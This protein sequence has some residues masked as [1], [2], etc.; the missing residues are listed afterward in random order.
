MATAAK[1]WR[2]VL[3]GRPGSGKSS[4]GESIAAG[5]GFTLV[6]TGELLRDA[7][8][9]GDSL[10]LEV[11][12]LLRQG[13]LVS[14]ELIGGLIE[15]ILREL[16]HADVLFDGYPRSIGQVPQ[17]EAF[18]RKLGFRVDTYLEIAVDRD[19]AVRRMGGRR[20]CSV[21][22]ATYHLLTRPPRVEGVCDLDQ[23]PLETRRDDSVEVIARR[24]QVYEEVT[25]PV[26]EYYRSHDPSRFRSV[27]GG[28]THD[29]VNRD[30]LRALGLADAPTTRGS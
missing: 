18:E 14:D 20:V 8:K 21:C 3:F 5:F 7:V 12:R 1:R 22:G 26:V 13:R 4:L 10:G 30:A 16:Q 25:G 24:Q 6:R 9:R 15:P 27:D 19:A 23:A 29:E 11:D 17:L 2:L 28:R